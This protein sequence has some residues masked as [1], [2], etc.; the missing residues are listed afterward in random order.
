MTSV[1]T[2]HKG[3]FNHDLELIDEAIAWVNRD[4]AP[5]DECFMSTRTDPYTYGNGRFARTYSPIPFSPM[6]LTIQRTLKLLLDV[7]YEACFSNKYIDASKHLGWHADDSPSIDHSV[8][9]AVVSYGAERE[10]WIRETPEQS[11]ISRGVVHPVTKLALPHG[12]LLVMHPGMQQTHQHRIP[13]HSAKCGPRI[14][15]TFRKLLG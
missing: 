7:D 6:I 15:L 11:P 4:D 5:R 2:L 14:S 12:S 9:I 13:K 1:F 8:G 10:L 3:A